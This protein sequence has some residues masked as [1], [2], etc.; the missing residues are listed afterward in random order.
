M[1]KPKDTFQTLFLILVM[2]LIFLPFFTTFNDIITRIVIWF[3]FFHV[4]RD[5][6]VPWEI[7]MIGGMLMPFG[8]KP[9]IIGEYLAITQSG[10]P[11]LLEIAWNCVG[12]QSLL[13][14]LITGWVGF[15]GDKYTNSSKYKAWLIGLLGTILI[16]LIRICIV[17]LLAYYLGQNI[18]LFFHDYGS[19]FVIIGWLFVYWWFS[20]SYVLEEKNANTNANTE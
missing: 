17:V 15:Q 19:T 1:H 18:A 20:Y 14:F 6:I 16:N 2:V 4:I 11:F 5:I 12:W 7:R 8:L 10:R 13:F 3:D 9:V